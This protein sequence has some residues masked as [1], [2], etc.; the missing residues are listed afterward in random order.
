[1]QFIYV[2][3]GWEGSAANNRVLRDIVHRPDGLRVL[4]GNYYLCNNGYENAKGFLTLYRGVRYH[5][6]EWDRG[7]REPQNQEELFNLKHSSGFPRKIDIRNGYLAQ[8]EAHM[9]KNFPHGDIRA[10]PHIT[11]KLHVWKKHYSILTTMMTKFG[12]G[13]DES[14]N[15]VTVEDD[16]AWDDYV[17]V[18]LNGPY[19]KGDVYRSWSFYTTWI[20]IFGKDSATEDC[21][22]NRTRM[23]MTSQLRSWGARR[24]ATYQ[25]LNGIQT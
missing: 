10:E 18:V 13:W 4:A 6:R 22:A 3:A 19:G 11:S 21:G 7:Y 12:L 20:E 2:F 8:L 15:M 25:S 24:I 14:R 9:A 1:M 23:P 5:L 16:N 17:K